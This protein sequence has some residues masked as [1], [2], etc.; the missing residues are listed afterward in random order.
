MEQIKVSVCC[1]AYNQEKY[2]RRCL[3]GFVNQQC[4]FPFEVI[5]HDDASTDNT[6]RIIQEYAAKYPNIIKPIIQ[7]ENQ[8]SKGVK[9]SGSLVLPVAK[10][11]YYAFCEGDDY[12]TDPYKLEKQVKAMDTHPS[13]HLCLHSVQGIRENETPVGIMYPNFSLKTGVFSGARLLDYICTNEYV[14]QTTSYFMR[15]VDVRKYYENLPEFSKVSATGDTPYLLYCATLGDVYY[16]S[17]TM[18]CYRHTN[19]D[20]NPRKAK[21]MNTEEKI[22]AHYN[23]QIRMME[24]FDKYTDGKY[25]MLCQRKINGYHFDNAVRNH[26]YR[27]YAKPKYRFFR[28]NWSIKAKVKTFLLAYLPFIVKE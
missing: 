6:P 13:C 25:H 15:T 12:W 9:I 8:Y 22:M 4:S 24:E 2:I 26:D 23:K 20:Q 27:E 5:V 21:Y 3:D 10:G 16:L 17:D 1:T 28:R 18:S 19:L 7:K 11:V 14:F